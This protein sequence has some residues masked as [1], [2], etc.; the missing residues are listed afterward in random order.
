MK[1]RPAA[2]A[3]HN[4]L[5][6]ALGAGLSLVASPAA[7][8]DPAPPPEEPAPPEVKKIPAQVRI[9]SRILEWQLTNALDFDFAV[10]FNRNPPTL[11]PITG[12]I[13]D[14]PGGIVRTADLTL[15]ASSP[16]SSAGR[17]F[18]SGLDSGSGSF[19]GV[20]ETLETVGKITVLSELD[21]I[22]KVG[23]P[24][25]G[26]SGAT[27]F[28]GK[29]SSKTMIPYE[30]VK[31]FGGVRLATTT[32]FANEGVSLQCSALDIV[33]GEFIK[34]NYAASITDNSGFINVGV[35]DR[36]EA[37]RVPVMDSRSIE[38]NLIVRN[39]AVF[40]AGLLKSTREIE[41]RQGIPWLSELPLLRWLF[42]NLSRDRQ[43][44]EL[45]F[46][47]RAEIIEPAQWGP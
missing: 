37:L 8:Q 2:A 1:S 32:E 29:V 20:I 45:V 46:L 41:R 30:A 19:E 26:E 40:I 9:E 11:D 44:I 14:F 6:L 4:L 16:L 3:R 43:V 17:V 18:L 5:L 10:L 24:P 13:L 25:D 22:V 47:V 39:R 27:G 35:N 38:S 7:A 31:P 12:E 34:L 23:K 33:Q 42:S 21:V 15:P 28:T 36:N